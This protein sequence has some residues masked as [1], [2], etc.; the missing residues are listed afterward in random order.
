[1]RVFNDVG[2]W[3]TDSNA[4]ARAAG[5][6]PGTFY[7]HFGDKRAIFLA[8]YQMW[9]QL[10]QQELAAR[11]ARAKDKG[12]DVAGAF[13]DYIVEHHA[14]WRTFRASMRALAASDPEMQRAIRAHRRHHLALL[15]KLVGNRDVARGLVVLYTLDGLSDAIAADDPKQH[16]VRARDVTDRVRGLVVG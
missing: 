2:F 14:R 13:V 11:M 10:E 8:A 7:R 1:M 5:Y 6:S 4:L 9:A 12:K 3:G 15:G 16:G